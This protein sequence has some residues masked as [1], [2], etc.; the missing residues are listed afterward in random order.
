MDGADTLSHLAKVA[1]EL[2]VAGYKGDEDYSDV[3]AASYK[4][5]QV[6][7]PLE[8]LVLV[9]FS[10]ECVVTPLIDLSNVKAKPK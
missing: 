3:D 2:F 6:L 5:Q 7:E 1:D 4:I 10:W 8:G 9:E